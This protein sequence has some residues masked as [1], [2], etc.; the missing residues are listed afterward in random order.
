MI[1]VQVSHGDVSRIF[2][3]N[4]SLSFSERTIAVAQENSCAPIVGD[5]CITLTNYDQIGAAI[6]VEISGRKLGAIFDGGKNCG[7][8]ER[9]DSLSEQEGHGF[10]L[11]RPRIAT[12]V[13]TLG[14]RDAGL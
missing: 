1:S 7:R 13:F 5:G 3:W 6:A 12:V 9:N 14:G 11:T 8:R 10:L 2:A 4:E